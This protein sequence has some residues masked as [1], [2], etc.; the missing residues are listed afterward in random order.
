MPRKKT[1]IIPAILAKNKTEFIKQFKK[2][3]PYFTYLQIDIM[4]GQFVKTKNSITPDNIKYI[5]RKNKLEIHLMV[6]DV[7]KHITRWSKLKSVKKIIWHYEANKN[8]KRILAINDYLKNKKIKTGLAINPHTSL[9]KIKDIIRYFDTIQIMGVTP[10]K[11]GQRF[12]PKIIPKIKALRYKFPK[13]NVEVDGGVS[14]KNFRSLH[15]AGANI[16]SI[17]S[18]LQKAPSIKKAL[19]KLK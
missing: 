3:S 18:Y 13:I 14:N 19:D 1:K 6:T 15:R 11:Q 8:T 9:A 17:G 5:T 2:V 4:D 12:Q 10:G 7:S 16:I